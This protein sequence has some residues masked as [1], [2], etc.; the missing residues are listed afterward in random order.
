MRLD[1]LDE[2]GHEL[3]REVD[4]LRPLDVAADGMQEPE[5]SVGGVVLERARV[6]PHLG[7]RPGRLKLLNRVDL[8]LLIV[9]RVLPGS[10]SSICP[11]EA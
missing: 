10:R 1:H 11:A 8:C 5:R 6:G 7:L 9:H 4:V 3:G 2:P